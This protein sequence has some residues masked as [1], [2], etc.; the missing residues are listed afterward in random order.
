[1]NFTLSLL[2]E[3]WFTTFAV[4][5]KHGISKRIYKYLLKF[6]LIAE[7][8]ILGETVFETS[9]LGHAIVLADKI[10]D[11]LPIRCPSCDGHIDNLIPLTMIDSPIGPHDTVECYACGTHTVFPTVPLMAIYL[12]RILYLNQRQTG[13]YLKGHSD[14]ELMDY[15]FNGRENLVH[16]C[17]LYR[18]HTGPDQPIKFTGA[19]LAAMRQIA[20]SENPQNQ[21]C[22]TLVAAV[23]EE[24]G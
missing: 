18:K 14:Q 16:L 1:M 2:K 20:A 15:Y 4:L 23:L 21:D 5:K 19:Q 24:H 6:G 7:D 9:R 13:H 11:C 12:N 10:L 3:T 17:D 8:K 22:A